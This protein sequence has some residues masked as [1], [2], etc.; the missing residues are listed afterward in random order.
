[1]DRKEVIRMAL[2]AG[3]PGAG[4]HD[5]RGGF[6]KMTL[7]EQDML[8]AVEY[9]AALVAAEEREAC[10]ELRKTLNLPYGY[11]D[12]Q[13]DAWERGAEDYEDAIRARGATDGK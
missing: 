3:L 1:M 4:D 5:F 13:K 8:L 9:F 2:E 7:P 12:V 10:A 11:K 6:D